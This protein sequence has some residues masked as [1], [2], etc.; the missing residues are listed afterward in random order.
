M[1]T[2][3][4]TTI[5]VADDDPVIRGNLRLLLEHEGYAVLEANDGDQA[6]KLFAEHAVALVLLDLK[7]PG[8]GGM[9]FLREHQ[10]QLEDVPVIVITA[11]GGSR[12]AIEAMKLGAFDYITKP[13]DLDEVLFTVRR[14]LTQKNLVAQVQAMAVAESGGLDGT[15]DEELL[16]RTPAMLEVFKTIGRVAASA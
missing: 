13:F 5:L 9:E 1:A 11:F 3:S 6:G 16:G 8:R 2:R 4:K 15:D 7:M 10:D 12:P 14:A